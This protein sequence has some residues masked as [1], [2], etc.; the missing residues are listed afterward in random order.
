MSYTFAIENG[1]DNIAE[2]KPL[3]QRHYGEM[4]ARL[5]LE[6]IPVG[7]F[8]MRLDVYNQRWRDG[9]LI[10]YV[11][12]HDGEAVGYANIYLSNSMHSGEFIAIED[13]IYMRPDHRNGT[14]RKLAKFALTDLKGRG[15]KRLDIQARTDPRAVKL[16]QRMGFRQSAVAMSL[17]F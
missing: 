8:N 11:A 14:G 15:V 2:L 6:G 13:A 3:Y 12:R 9:T 17:V 7:P 5:A 1:A 10:N 4:Q 16:W